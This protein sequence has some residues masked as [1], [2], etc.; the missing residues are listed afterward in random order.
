LDTNWKII[1]D[2]QQPIF[3][4]THDFLMS[5]WASHPFWLAAD[6][7][8]R[9]LAKAGTHDFLMSFWASHPFWLAADSQRRVLAKAG[10][11]VFDGVFEIWRLL[12][13]CTD[14]AMLRLYTAIAVF[15]CD[16]TTN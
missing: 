11:A 3:G 16:S 2:Y 14:V 12:K 13:R 1:T 7:Q 10:L 8:R 6:S 5:F 9:V 4:F 15:V